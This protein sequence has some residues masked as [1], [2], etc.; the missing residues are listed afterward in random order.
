MANLFRNLPR[1]EEI[2]AFRAKL[3]DKIKTKLNIHTCPPDTPG[4]WVSP[5][6]TVR[7]IVADHPSDPTAPYQLLLAMDGAKLSRSSNH[8]SPFSH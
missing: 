1:V 2:Q 6:D 5:I 3:N 8:V 4:V 7:L